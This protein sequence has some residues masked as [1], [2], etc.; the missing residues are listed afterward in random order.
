MNTILNWSLESTLVLSIL[1]TIYFFCFRNNTSVKLRRRL[2]LLTLVLSL[3]API[4]KID[5]SNSGQWMERNIIDLDDR[6]LTGLTPIIG[7]EPDTIKPNNTHP[8]DSR[9]PVNYQLLIYKIGFASFSIIMLLQLGKLFSILVT[10]KWSR[11]NGS[12]IVKH[13]RV[14]SPSSFLFAI[15]LPT[16]PELSDREK[17]IIIEHERQHLI[18]RHSLDLLAI[19]VLQVFMWF[20]PLLF[21]IRTEFKNLHEVLADKATLKEVDYKD[22]FEVLLAT[23]FTVSSF[24]LSH[25]F[26]QK[27]GLLKRIELM[28]KQQTTMKSTR[29]SI[30]LFILLSCGI[31]GINILQGQESDISFSM[32]ANKTP[33]FNKMRLVT[34][35]EGFVRGMIPRHKRVMSR[36]EEENPFKEFGYRYFEDNSFYNH[37]SQNVRNMKPVFIT[38]LTKLEKSQLFDVIK[39]DTSRTSF[40]MRDETGKIDKK[41]VTYGEETPELKNIIEENYNYLMIYEYGMAS[42]GIKYGIVYNPEDVDQQPKILG[43]KSDF[44]RSVALEFELPKGLKK[45]KLP[46]TVDFSFVVQGGGE[47][48]DIRLLTELK[49]DE[50]K[51]APYYLFFGQIH[52]TLKSKIKELYPWRRGVK[53]GK[54]VL[55]RVQVSIPTKYMM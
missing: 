13:R 54:E 11:Y 7:V 53:D 47:I 5:T 30:A 39:E 31:L 38:K 35:K 3:F 52:N 55:V 45:S 24:N 19:S 1:F 40:F 25:C 42:E 29:F 2:L 8:E 6:I 44:E 16:K 51:N 18:Q 27:K 20:N 36:I 17:T 46:E 15:M 12:L 37:L 10:G 48:S 22:Y 43:G 9:A 23:T 33:D 21:W 34:I 4:I 26:G 32:A 14:K 41:H 28:K 49:G 50:D